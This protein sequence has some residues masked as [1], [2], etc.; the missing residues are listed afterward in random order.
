MGIALAESEK[1]GIALPGLALVKQMY[2]ALQAQGHNRLGT[3]ALMLALERLNGIDG[4]DK[5]Q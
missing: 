4:I 3:Q 2:V 1:M 5:L